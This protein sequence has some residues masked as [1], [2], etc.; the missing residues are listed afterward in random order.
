MKRECSDTLCPTNDLSSTKNIRVL[1]GARNSEVGSR[2]VPKAGTWV[3]EI[4]W[5]VEVS[6]ATSCNWKK[7]YAGLF[8]TEVKPLEDE[9][10][11]LKNIVVDLT[12]DREMSSAEPKVHEMK[13]LKPDR[14]HELVRGIWR[15]WAASIGQACG[16]IE[17][18]RSTFHDQSRRSSHVIWGYSPPT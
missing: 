1:A 10:A 17:F 9:N 3:A 18:A 5:K 16:A 2:D 6:Q 15:D 12:R 11:G 7:K 14:L 8:P 4:C 13:A